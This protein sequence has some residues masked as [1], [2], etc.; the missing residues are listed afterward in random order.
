ML[1]D[2]CRCPEG[3]ILQPLKSQHAEYICQ[4]WPYFDHWPRKVNYVRECIEKFPSMAAYV[5]DDL[6]QPVSWAGTYET[7]EM[8]LFYT[9]DEHRKNG[10]GLAVCAGMYKSFQLYSTG[11][12]F[13]TTSKNSSAARVVEKLGFV[14][15]DDVSYYIEIFG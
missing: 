12:L 14:I 9:I 6:D 11:T 5:G 7:E 4:F 2:I 8:G 10:I 3:Y 1:N 13:L 15:P